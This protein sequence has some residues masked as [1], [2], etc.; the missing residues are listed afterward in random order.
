MAR[1]KGS[2]TRAGTSI[3]G[4]ASLQGG[5]PNCLALLAYRA[6]SNTS[7]EVIGVSRLVLT[8]EA[9]RVPSGEISSLVLVITCLGTGR[10]GP[11]RRRGEGPAT[12]DEPPGSR[13]PGLVMIT[14]S[15]ALS[16]PP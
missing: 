10:L 3:A 5:I 12:P 4:R 11:R 16:A 7:A 6:F 8:V 9:H 15:L 1:T 2:A 14:L 13:A